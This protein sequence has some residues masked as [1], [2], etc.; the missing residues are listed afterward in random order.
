M[1]ISSAD[2]SNVQFFYK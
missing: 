2:V 1:E